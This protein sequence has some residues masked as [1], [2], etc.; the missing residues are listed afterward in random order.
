VILA[1]GLLIFTLECKED[2]I[3]G[4]WEVG[5]GMRIGMVEGE[6]REAMRSSREENMEM[7]KDG[8]LCRQVE[9]AVFW[10]VGF[11]IN[12]RLGLVIVC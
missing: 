9:G 1:T 3:R 11:L 8:T 2:K 10:T 7:L 4:K 5:S 6:T 12:L